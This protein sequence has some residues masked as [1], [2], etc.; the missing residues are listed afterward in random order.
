[1]LLAELSLYENLK[2][3][4]ENNFIN[5]VVLIIGLYFIW[6]KYITPILTDS[7]DKTKLTIADAKRANQEASLNLDEQ[8]QKFAKLDASV[9]QII[10]EA[11]D[12]LNLY[13]W[14]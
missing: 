14:Y 2:N 9:N 6:N 12:L 13:N 7:A 3:V 11:Q 10:S 1:M 8:K 4:F 5:W